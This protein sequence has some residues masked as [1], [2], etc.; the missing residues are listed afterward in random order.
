MNL[1]TVLDGL[2]NATSTS[3]NTII[4]QTPIGDAWMSSKERY[5]RDAVGPDA[6]ISVP[7]SGG[8]LNALPTEIV[9]YLESTPEGRDLLNQSSVSAAGGFTP[10]GPKMVEIYHK[11][12]E[13]VISYDGNTLKL[14]PAQVKAVLPP[15]FRDI[16]AGIENLQ[17]TT[18]V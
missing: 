14:T 11:F 5:D 13:L 10:G 15:L 17:P 9:N 8:P 6:P 1:Q 3:F 16:S 18:P 4:G 2:A 12:S 7:G